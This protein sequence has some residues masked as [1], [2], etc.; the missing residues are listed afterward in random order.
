MDRL[1]RDLRT[2]IRE[3]PDFPRKGVL[4]RDLT[5][6]LLDP[7]LLD[8]VISA[9]ARY[10]R[11]RRA[12]ALAAVESRGFIFGAALAL[13]TQLPFVPIRK[14]GKL[15]WKCVRQAIRLEYGTDLLEIHRDALRRG[16]R[17]V[18]LDDVLA[19]G[20]TLE[21]A[22]R[23]VERIGGVVAGCACVVELGDLHGRDRLRGRDLFSLVRY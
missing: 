9:L 4:F 10:V 8:R 18:V 21:G 11:R 19:T 3:V 17:A 7:G 12:E 23:L 14:K 6:L 13:R 2:R 1:E 5:P 16:Q 20:G 22:C 15:P